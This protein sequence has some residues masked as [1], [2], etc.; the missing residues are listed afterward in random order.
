[1]I[2]IC[3]QYPGNAHWSPPVLA[4]HNSGYTM[5]EEGGISSAEVELV[6]ETGSPSLLQN[7][8]ASSPDVK[9]FVTGTVTFNSEVQTQTFEKIEMDSDSRYM[10][11]I[12]MVAPR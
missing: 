1:M 11:T 12:T 6:A 5:W 2:L 10:S 8:L 7:E 9:D 3:F 4:A